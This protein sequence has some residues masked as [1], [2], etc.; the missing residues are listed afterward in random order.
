M[1]KNRQTDIEAPWDE[2]L[3]RCPF[4]S[5]RSLTEGELARFLPEGHQ[6]T[7]LEANTAYAIGL[8]PNISLA[9]TADSNNWLSFIPLGPER[10]RVVGGY[11]VRPG[12][13]TA[14]PEAAE[15]R[16]NLLYEVN[17]EDAQATWRLQKVLRSTRARPGPLNVREGTCAQFYKYLGR[18]LAPDRVAAVTD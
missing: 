10:T 18:T 17:E 8:F 3:L 6:F 15:Q 14:E 2:N 9:M 12:Y 5:N 1:T 7:D 13:D 4:S 16:N 11:L